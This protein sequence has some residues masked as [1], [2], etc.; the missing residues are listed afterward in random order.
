MAEEVLRRNTVNKLAAAVA[1]ESVVAFVAPDVAAAVAV[2]AVVAE[3]VTLQHSHSSQ[4]SYQKIQWFEEC[5]V[6]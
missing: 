1:V 3:A 4:H 2:A 5:S 6:S